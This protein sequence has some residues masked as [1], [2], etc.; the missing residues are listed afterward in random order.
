MVPMLAACK[1]SAR[2]DLPRE[3]GDRGLAA[4]AGDRG[5]GA[6]LAREKFRR[7]QGQRAARV[8]H[9]HEGDCG[10][11]PVRTLLGGNR[12]RAGR[13]R[14]LGEMRAVGLGAGNGEKQE[15]RFDLAAVGGNAG[16]LDAGMCAHRSS[17]SGRSSPSLTA[18]P[19][20]SPAAI[21]RPSADRSAAGCRAAAPR[22]RSPWR[23][24]APRSIPRWR[25]RGFRPGPAVR[26]S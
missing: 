1:P 6:G 4:G 14:L 25:S 3:G 16:D 22:V 2:P 9:R 19:S 15:A 24:P 26:R 23:R 5:D 10:G 12:H 11:Q 20:R 18:S 8:V 21:D 13:R 7:R 17:I